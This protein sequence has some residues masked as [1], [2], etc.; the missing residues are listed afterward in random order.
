MNSKVFTKPIETTNE[1][2][3]YYVKKTGKKPTT[4]DEVLTYIKGRGYGNY[5]DDK[6]SN[7][8]VIGGF[9]NSSKSLN[10]NCTDVLQFLINMAIAMSYDWKCVHVKC[11][12]SGTGHVFGKFKHKTHTGGKWITRNPA[13]VL[14]G[15]GISS[16][17]CSDGYVQAINPPWFLANLNR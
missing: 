3:K 2:Y 12:S 9:V 11:K 16:V 13:S 5:F 7:K 17:W 15:G 6:L 10:A 8:Q 1:V 4:I 14:N